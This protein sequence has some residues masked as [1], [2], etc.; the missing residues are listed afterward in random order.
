MCGLADLR[1][2][3]KGTGSS[4]FVSTLPI[5]RHSF[6]GAGLGQPGVQRVHLEAQPQGQRMKSILRV[7]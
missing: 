5:V 3:I 2:R 7:K 6:N 1:A 4:R